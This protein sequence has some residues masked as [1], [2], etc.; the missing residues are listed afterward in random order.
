MTA[1][2]S[3]SVGQGQAGLFRVTAFEPPRAARVSR[4]REEAGM[5]RSF[6]G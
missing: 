3:S 4:E 1:S 2:I 6:E 5:G